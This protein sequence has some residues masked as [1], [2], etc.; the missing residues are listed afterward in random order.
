MFGKYAGIPDD[1]DIFYDANENMLFINSEDGI[2]SFASSL[3]KLKDR[4]P[5]IRKEKHHYPL[6]SV[7]R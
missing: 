3:E 4:P 5:I 7:Y 2:R 6:V 1:G